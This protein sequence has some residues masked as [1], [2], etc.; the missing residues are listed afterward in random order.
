MERRTFLAASTTAALAPPRGLTAADPSGAAASPAGASPLLL[1]LRRYRLRNGPMTARFSAYTKD[2]LVPA[3]GRAGIAPVGAWNVSLGSDSPTL[4][5]LLPHKDAESLLSL[6]TRLA[7]DAEYAKAATSFLALPPADPPFERCDSSLIGAVPT[8]PGI[9]KPK[10]DAAAASRSYELRTYHS[11]SEPA[12]LRKVEMFEAGGELA[13][14]R[15]LGFQVVFFGRD[16]IGSGLPCLTYMLAWPD[17][18]AREKGW[19]AFR[20]DP[21][22]LKLR[23]LPQ[24]ADIVSG[25]DVS[26][27]RATDYSQI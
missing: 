6:D 18:V 5:L 27:L 19:I 26:V 16:L 9:D 11:P 23:D 8:Q 21:A 20:D 4:H 2:A 24:N 25:I 15:R 17:P 10:G 14:F 12:G 3:L 22:W 7:A 1:E 13:I